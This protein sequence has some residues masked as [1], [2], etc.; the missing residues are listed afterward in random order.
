MG[1]ELEKT[2]SNGEFGL[3]FIVYCVSSSPYSQTRFLVNMLWTWIRFGRWAS[4]KEQRPPIRIQSPHPRPAREWKLRDVECLAQ[5]YT[6][7][8][9]EVR[10]VFFPLTNSLFSW[11]TY[12]TI[13][14]PGGSTGGKFKY[15]KIICINALDNKP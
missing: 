9:S 5:G 8:P 1:E 4:D 14:D 7:L 3:F 6:A 13:S 15:S 10:S 2:M 11:W 12:Q